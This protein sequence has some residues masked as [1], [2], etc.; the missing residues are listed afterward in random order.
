L[1]GSQ[2]PKPVEWHDSGECV[3][4]EELHPS[5]AVAQQAGEDIFEARGPFSRTRRT[6]RSFPPRIKE[7]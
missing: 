5:G 4:T 2:L 3:D 1:I 6:R 7:L